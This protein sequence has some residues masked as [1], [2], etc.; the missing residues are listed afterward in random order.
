MT[1]AASDALSH[2]D[3]SR[4]EGTIFSRIRRHPIARP[5]PCEPTLRKLHG[6][7][8]LFR[9]WMHAPMSGTQGGKSRAPFNRPITS[10]KPLLDS[11]RLS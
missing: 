8:I 6:H 1:A 7:S 4:F 10:R 5:C 3:C 2:V 11:V 9:H